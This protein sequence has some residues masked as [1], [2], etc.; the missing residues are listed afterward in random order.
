MALLRFILI[1]IIVF[2]L[3]R[4]FTR[5]LLPSLFVNY[6]D[7]KMEAFSMQQQK[8]QQHQ[9]E[10]AR[11]REGEVTIEVKPGGQDRNKPATGDYVDYVEVKD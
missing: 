2:Y 4:M 7:S 1:F 9:R 8:Q 10:K 3:I 5:Y 6:M 11:K